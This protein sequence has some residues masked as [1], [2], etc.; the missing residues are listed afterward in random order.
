MILNELSQIGTLVL[1]EKQAAVIGLSIR[2]N[3]FRGDTIEQITL[4]AK[5]NF[6]ILIFMIP[7]E[8]AIDTLCGLGYD[9][10]KAK[11]K[12][13]QACN[14][15][16]NKCL[17]I[18]SKLNIGDKART[19]RWHQL[20]SN[21]AYCNSYA[22]LSELYENDQSF[23]RDARNTTKQVMLAQETK[24]PIEQ[25]IDIGVQFLIKELSFIIN[26]SKILELD[27]AS[28]YLYHRPLAIY[29]NLLDGR[30]LFTPPID[31]GY[32]VCEL[33]QNN[34]LRN[35][36]EDSSAAV[37]GEVTSPSLIKSSTAFSK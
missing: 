5:D 16:E 3:Y 33:E 28:A 21:T 11:Q 18:I 15:L 35:T 36:I 26:A 22:N 20:Q 34:I 6:R 9:F 13:T 37:V 24:L 19:L 4:W 31:S 14:N 2:N 1:E 25:A 23:R 7:D 30:Y 8:P 17:R 10:S 32:I 12:A 27:C 29:R